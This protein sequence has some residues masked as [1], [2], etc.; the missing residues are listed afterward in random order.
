MHAARGPVTFLDLHTTS[1]PGIPFAMVRNEPERRAFAEQFPLPIIMGLL[2]LVDNTLLEF[3]RTRGCVT[4]GVE[5]GQ[6][7]AESSVDH[8]EAVL[9]Q[10]LASAGLAREKDLPDLTPYRAVLAAARR[11]VPHVMVV[12]Q[13]HAIGPEDDFRMEPG[14][15]NIERVE[16]GRL[17]AHDRRGEIRAPRHCILLLPLYQPQGDD[18]FF[19]GRELEA[20]PA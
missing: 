16:A 14:F 20:R 5:A 4:L 19:L 9:W 2:E 3:M 11:D 13:R 7:D 18:G 12:E 8:H 15:G 17:L 6:N 10:A 1:A